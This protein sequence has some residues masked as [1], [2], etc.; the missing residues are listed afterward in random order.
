M[1]TAAHPDDPPEGVAA[2]EDDI[3]R[4]R[5]EL[6]DTVDALSDKLDA[7]A[8]ARP[9][10]ARA[11]AAVLTPEGRPRPETLALA[12]VAAAGVV[13]LLLARSRR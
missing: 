9:Y 3:R 6:R 1:T 13:V 4:T 8:R 10:L 11:R 2:I 7:G 5:A 12:A